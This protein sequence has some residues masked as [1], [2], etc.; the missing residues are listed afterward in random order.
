MYG[1]KD[2]SEWLDNQDVCLLSNISTR[3]WQTLRDNDTLAYFQINNKTY[4]KP[5]DVEAIFPLVEEKRK[6]AK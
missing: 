5:Q 4:Y 3:T 1:D 2:I 6:Q